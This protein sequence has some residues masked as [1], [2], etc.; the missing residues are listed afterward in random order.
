M[1]VLRVP[2]AVVGE[3]PRTDHR[4]PGREC[5]YLTST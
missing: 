5:A 3:P 2:S 1:S 4:R